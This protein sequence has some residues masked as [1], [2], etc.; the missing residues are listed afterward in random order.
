MG[1]IASCG[2]LYHSSQI[3]LGYWHQ[4]GQGDYPFYQMLFDSRQERFR[5]FL[6]IYLTGVNYETSISGWSAM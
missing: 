2:Y 4:G 3:Q 5:I 1:E 6:D